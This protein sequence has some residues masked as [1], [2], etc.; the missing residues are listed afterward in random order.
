[1]NDINILSSKWRS[2]YLIGSHLITIAQ[3][4]NSSGD[5]PELSSSGK[6]EFGFQ[7]LLQHGRKVDVLLFRHSI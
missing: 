7:G 2:K 4:E 1:M 3:P 6:I 5:Y